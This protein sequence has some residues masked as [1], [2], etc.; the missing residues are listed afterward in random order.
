MTTKQIISL[1]NQFQ[2]QKNVQRFQYN[3]YGAFA[4]KCDNQVIRISMLEKKFRVI[5]SGNR[6]AFQ[7]ETVQAEI[8]KAQYNA[9]KK[10][11]E[12]KRDTIVEP[13]IEQLAKPK[14]KNRR[15]GVAI[16]AFLIALAFSSCSTEHFT[17]ISTN[18]VNMG[19]TYTLKKSGN[20][21][22]AFN[23]DDAVSKCIGDGVYLTNVTI[24]EGLFRYKVKGDVY[25][26]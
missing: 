25:G 4:C 5:Y 2:K 6:K 22:R 7:N 23:M 9:M 24:S 16:I 10:D 21:A 13:S 26:K 1:W 14:R 17:I 11:V 8:T 12:G 20:V 3:D 18:S 19:E 15:T